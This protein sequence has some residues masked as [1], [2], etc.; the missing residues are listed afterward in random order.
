[1][2]LAY[3]HTKILSLFFQ[4]IFGLGSLKKLGLF[5]LLSKG[6]SAD[7]TILNLVSKCRCSENFL[8]LSVKSVQWFLIHFTNRQSNEH[9]RQNLPWSLKKLLC[10]TPC[11]GDGLA[12]V[13]CVHVYICVSF[14]GSRA[15]GGIRNVWHLHHSLLT[16]LCAPVWSINSNINSATLWLFTFNQRHK[17]YVRE[18]HGLK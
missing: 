13:H 7:V 1:M 17:V 8:R 3:Y 6:Q 5:L 11:Q 4:L 12:H 10:P 15:P 14:N 16:S 2:T 18:Q 9:R